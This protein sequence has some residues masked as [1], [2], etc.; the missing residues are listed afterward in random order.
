MKVVVKKKQ[1]EDGTTVED[2]RFLIARDKTIIREGT[3]LGYYWGMCC[4]CRR[5]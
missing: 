5:I 3:L 1:L 2:A 4:T